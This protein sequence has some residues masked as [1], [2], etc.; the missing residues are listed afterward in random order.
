MIAKSKEVIFWDLVLQ[1]LNGSNEKSKY[2]RI[3]L[4]IFLFFNPF[5]HVYDQWN[6][7]LLNNK[8]QQKLNNETVSENALSVIFA[9]EYFNRILLHAPVYK[10][11]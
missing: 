11:Y 6:L 2:T 3:F 4:C 10:R 7:N 9:I 1:G 5:V 8:Q